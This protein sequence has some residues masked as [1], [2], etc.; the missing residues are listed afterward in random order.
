VDLDAYRTWARELRPGDDADLRAL[1]L[2]RASALRRA[3]DQA[4]IYGFVVDAASLDDL[5]ALL[6]TENVHSVNVADVGFD[7]SAQTRAN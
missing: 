1:G 7:P 2:P 5:R 4:G 6:G 3:A